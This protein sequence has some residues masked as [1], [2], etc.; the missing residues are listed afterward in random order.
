MKNKMPLGLKLILAFS[1]FGVLWDLWSVTQG[2]YQFNIAV[3]RVTYDLEHLIIYIY[4]ATQLAWIISVF[5]RYKWGWKLFIA[6]N[7]LIALNVILGEIIMGFILKSIA[8]SLT[9]ILMGAI[10]IYVYKNR[11]YFNR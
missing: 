8:P 10:S 9:L 7:L 3:P 5:K 6:T 11:T 1:I 4:W 2:T